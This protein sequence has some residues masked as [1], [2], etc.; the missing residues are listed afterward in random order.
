MV[1]VW[2]YSN[3]ALRVK[4][5][6]RMVTVSRLHH[7]HPE[8][9]LTVAK[10]RRAVIVYV[11]TVARCQQMATVGRDLLLLQIHV[12]EVFQGTLMV[13]VRPYRHFHHALTVAQDFQMAP[14]LSLLHLRPDHALRALS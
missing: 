12:P 2:M 5:E 10:G 13:N 14:V 9:V 1:Y 6:M 7:L 11:L 4:N 8:C 3:H